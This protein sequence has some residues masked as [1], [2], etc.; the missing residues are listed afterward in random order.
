MSGQ[1]KRSSPQP[2]KRI[3]H[4]VS[5]RFLGEV[6][7]LRVELSPSGLPAP[8]PSAVSAKPFSS[9]YAAVKHEGSRRLRTKAQPSAIDVKAEF[10]ALNRSSSYLQSTPQ[11]AKSSA[12]IKAEDRWSVT[13]KAERNSSNSRLLTSSKLE[14]LTF[15]SGEEGAGL[16]GTLLEEVALA[17]PRLIDTLRVV[18]SRYERRIEQL[19]DELVACKHTVVLQKKELDGRRLHEGQL[20]GLLESMQ[21]KVSVHSS[22]E[23]T[24]Y[25]KQ[26]EFL[27]QVLNHLNSRG[28]PVQAAYAEVQKSVS[29]A[30]SGDSPTEPRPWDRPRIVPRLKLS[31]EQRPD[32]QAEFFAKL[33][34]FSESWKVQIPKGHQEA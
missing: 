10:G 6:E 14:S 20:Q 7:A 2:A 3:R 30:D 11:R 1:L 28:Y 9:P 24:N 16:A 19:T 8:S 22:A 33:E 26:N 5:R 18:K 17:H 15:D 13:P 12:K 4:F 31:H 32:F 25:K 23:E 27:L 34:E 21:G 29:T